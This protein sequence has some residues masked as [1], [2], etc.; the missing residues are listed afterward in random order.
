MI[1]KG[2]FYI[3]SNFEKVSG[4]IEIENAVFKAFGEGVSSMAKEVMDISGLTVLPGM[5]DIHTHGGAGADTCD[6]DEASMQTLS[7]YY[8]KCGTTSFCPTTMTLS[9]HELKRIFA[10]VESYKGKEAAAYI[11]GINMEGP[12][13]STE[14][15]G[16]Q[17][18]AYIKTADF[19]EFE[20]LNSISKVS[21]VDVAPETEGAMDFAKKASKLTTVS[22]AHTNA[23][24]STA[25]KAS[26]N[27]F[28]H[29]THFMNAMSAFESRSS[30]VVGAVM[31]E[32][33]LTA[34]LICDGFHLA[35][36]TVKILFKLLGDDRC[37]TISDSLSCAGCADGE[38]ALGGQ[39]VIVQNSEARLVDG[40]IAGSS[41]NMYAEFLN[42][43]DFGVPFK[44]ALKAC[45]LNPCKA[46]GVDDVA[47]TIE[48]GKNADMVLIDD[49]YA[50]KHVII[51]GKLIF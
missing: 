30:G 28:T 50:I 6:E 26:E 17:N 45:T 20:M 11:H 22:I 25:S 14:K 40:T 51:K 32:D 39:K 18:K 13:V 27:G 35:P 8:A 4:D 37:V 19:D 47:G 49:N 46:I 3:N 15:C 2:G 43:L 44:S 33:K 5:V 7:E 12:Y 34:E 36:S 31:Q 48:I 41:S 29:V 9:T 16:A 24:Y 42:L 38:Y 23:D 1:L 21:L 10:K